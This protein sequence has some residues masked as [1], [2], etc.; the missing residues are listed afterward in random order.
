[1]DLQLHGKTALVV[2]S[3]KG[4]GKA[5]AAELVREGCQ[6]MLTS[7]NREQLEATR[8]ELSLLGPG[9]VV[10]H[11]SDVTR[12][13]EIA[14]LV[15]A[16]RRELGP[17]DILF[18][19]SGGPPGGGFEQ[20]DDAA[21]QQAFELTLLNYIRL[22]REVLPDLK[23]RRGCILNN[24]SSSIKQPIP[25]LILSNVFRLG[26]VG[27][28]KSLAEEF[29][30][31]GVRVNLI[32]PGRI[33]TDRT[34]EL[35]ALKGKRLGITAEEVTRQAATNIPLGRYG[36]TEEFARVA[37]FLVSEA[38]SYLTGATLLVDGGLVRAI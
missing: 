12:S 25:G 8:L 29:A 26:F 11:P 23:E 37:A 20:L 32:A 9:P 38:S 13:D 10:C 27:L 6:V 21:W 18:N 24:A 1:M 2:A 19:N 28:T 3:S 7:R 31:F 16:T 34:D 30:P 14:N 5:V 22:I 4:L 33:T 15:A 36:R 35:D 17:L